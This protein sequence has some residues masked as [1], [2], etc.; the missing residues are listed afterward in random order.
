M[1][2]LQTD[3]GTGKPTILQVVKMIASASHVVAIVT[4][5]VQRY[6]VAS[7]GW[8]CS[9][10][11]GNLEEP[12]TPNYFLHSSWWIGDHLLLTGPIVLPFLVASTVIE[13]NN[14]LTTS[15]CLLTGIFLY[16][17]SSSLVS[18]FV[19]TFM[20]I[21]RW[22]HM[23]RNSMITVKRVYKAY[24]VMYLLP[25]PLITFRLVQSTDGCV[26][27][28]S[29]VAEGIVVLLCVL[30]A[31]F[32]YFKVFQIIRLHQNQ[33]HVNQ[34]THNFGQ[35]A[36]DIAILYILGLFAI[37]YLPASL[38]LIVML[39]Y[40]NFQFKVEVVM[41]TRILTSLYFLLSARNPLLYCWRMR[42]LRSKV[43]QLL[44]T[45]CH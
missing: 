8:K 11:D 21:N 28:R 9:D 16:G 23:K 15:L 14:Q 1:K 13:V 30:I 7:S 18:I 40:P 24:F 42:D 39:F 36:I 44:V 29:D 31:A 19:M 17:I 5:T 34:Q 4:C 43:T 12:V 20:S 3:P 38:F 32:F 26:F 25:I 45:I 35:P 37:C 22:L 2:I 33:I 6:Y 41:V 10:F 27:L